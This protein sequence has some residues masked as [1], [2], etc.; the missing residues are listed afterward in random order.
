[1]LELHK[2][3]WVKFYFFVVVPAAAAVV[4]VLKHYNFCII[5][6]HMIKETLHRLG[7]SSAIINIPL[8]ITGA[9]IHQITQPPW[10][11]W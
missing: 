5:S 6:R 8:N 4:V 7:M 11:L 10:T 9:A 3:L 1:M 2:L